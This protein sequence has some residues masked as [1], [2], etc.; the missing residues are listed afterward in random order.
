MRTRGRIPRQ[1]ASGIHRTS[2][3]DRDRTR[4]DLPNARA[5]LA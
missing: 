3:L 2:R 1:L 4:D 5:A